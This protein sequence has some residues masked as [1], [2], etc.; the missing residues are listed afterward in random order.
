MPGWLT[1]ILDLFGA[2]LIVAGIALVYVPAAFA[3]A[4]LACL[5]VSWKA[6]RE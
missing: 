4:G 5:A 2:A 3:V 6:T 1:T